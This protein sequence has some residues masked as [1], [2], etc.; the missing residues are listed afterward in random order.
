VLVVLAGLAAVRLLPGGYVRAALAA[1]ILLLAPGSLTLSALVSH[2][3][4]PRG[5]VFVCY[6]ALL[7]AVC[8]IFTS[9]VLYADGVSITAASTYWG[10][11]ALSTVLALVAEARLLLGR[12]GRGRRIAGQPD[13]TD[14][15]LSGAE[16][17]EAETPPVARREGYYA[18]LAVAAGATLLSGGLYSYDHLPHPAPAGYTWI[19]WT[20][21]QIKGGTVV[22]SSGTKL[23]FEIVHRQSDTNGF[24]LS[25]IWLGTRS[26]PLAKPLAFSIGPGKTFRGAVFI[27]PLP[28]GCTY[29]IVVTLTATQQIDPM[30]KK[31]QTWS[32]NA[33]LH[34][35][36]KSLKTCQ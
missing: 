17:H 4:R 32:I 25:A 35:P 19:A 9:L 5:V 2:Q 24:R 21:P 6:A 16:V 28:D 22:D 3:H 18:V 36:G 34:D 15:D 23:G 1:P 8:S 13:N 26:R 12:P 27:P 10:L 31:L 30:T 33:D 14:P 11:L 29:R 20:A 7:G